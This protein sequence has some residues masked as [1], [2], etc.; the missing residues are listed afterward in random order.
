MYEEKYVSSFLKKKRDSSQG[1]MIHYTPYF[2]HR[3]GQELVHILV[4]AASGT[5]SACESTAACTLPDSAHDRETTT[6]TGVLP[7]SKKYHQ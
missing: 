1:P 2:N 5:S 6:E 7:D 3:F 4:L